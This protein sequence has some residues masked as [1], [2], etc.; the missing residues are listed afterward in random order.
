MTAFVAYKICSFR[1]VFIVRNGW[2]MKIGL[3]NGNE[4]VVNVYVRVGEMVGLLYVLHNPSISYNSFKRFIMFPANLNHT[5][6]CV[7]H[8]HCIFMCF[9]TYCWLYV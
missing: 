6:S 8:G 7:T 2:I 1:M 9:V 3:W 4:C 5:M